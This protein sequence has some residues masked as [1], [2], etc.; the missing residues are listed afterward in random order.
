MDWPFTEKA[1]V[2][3]L[4]ELALQGDD[5][6]GLQCTLTNSKFQLLVACAVD[7]VACR[8][9]RNLMELADRLVRWQYKLRLPEYTTKCKA[10]AYVQATNA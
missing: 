1:G 7:C 2:R 4:W 8:N 10:N 5:T 9:Q 6:F 3:V